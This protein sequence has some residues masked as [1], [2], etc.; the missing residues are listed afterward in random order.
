MQGKAYLSTEHL[1]C[2]HKTLHSALHPHRKASA[3]GWLR[4]RCCCDCCRKLAGLSGWVAAS[5]GTMAASTAKL[6][7]LTTHSGASSVTAGSQT[8]DD[9]QK[10][11][12]LSS[13]FSKR[14]GG[15]KC[16]AEAHLT[17]ARPWPQQLQGLAPPAFD[18]E[19]ERGW[20]AGTVK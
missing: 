13:L 3:A 17:W 14:S 11:G 18:R 9:S 20:R 5:S 7:A 12:C 19:A 4:I 6:V 15:R 8:A 2:C 10:G 16:M 1:Q